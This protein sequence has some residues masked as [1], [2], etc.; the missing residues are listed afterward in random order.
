MQSPIYPSYYQFGIT[1][2]PLVAR[3]FLPSLSLALAFSACA[4]GPNQILEARPAGRTPIEKQEILRVACLSEAASIGN[5]ELAYPRGVFNNAPAP[6][7]RKTRRYKNICGKM[8]ANDL[9]SDERKITL[10]HECG[11]ALQQDYQTATPEKKPQY[12]YMRYICE[13]LTGADIH[14]D[15]SKKI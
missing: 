10:A 2:L 11:A 13:A 7:S 3:K 6:D 5:A 8:A 15:G 1:L 14:N 9:S 4:V 12:G